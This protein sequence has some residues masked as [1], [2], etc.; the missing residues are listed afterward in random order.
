MITHPGAARVVVD[1]AK[2]YGDV[3]DYGPVAPF[4]GESPAIREVYELVARVARTDATVLITGETGTGKEVVARTLHSLSRR[5]QELFIPVDCGA[6]APTLIESELF[7]HERGSFTGADRQHRG[8]FE[9]ARG[10]TLFLD[11]V[12]EMPVELQA[13][14]LRVL[15]TSIVERVGGSGPIRVDVRVV[16][17]TNRRLADAVAAGK[18]REDLMYRLNVFP[19]EVPPLRE[20]GDD[21]VHLA[22]HFLAELNGAEGTAKQLTAASRES[23]RRY[24]WPGTVRQLR[25]VVLRAFI[26]AEGVHVVI[27]G[28]DLTAR[29]QLESPPCVSIPLG[30]PIAAAERMLIQA[31]L[32]VLKGD[33]NK[34]AA[35]LQISL[36]T[37]YNRLSEYQA[38]S[39]ARVRAPTRTGLA[40]LPDPQGARTH[41]PAGIDPARGGGRR[42]T[43]MRPI[44]ASAP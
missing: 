26:L 15:E 16:A 19:I 33:K 39:R 21:V 2:S 28:R 13:R 41:P 11:E 20:R 17:A 42:P 3:L 30:T 5:R 7:G 44:P 38:S 1:D 37:L 25:T 29:G 8:Y 9:R 36:K 22:E 6:I 31:T 4:V 40:G 35:I 32:D 27:P 24:A 43:P 10:G 12:T 34:A 18:L 23:L 14:L